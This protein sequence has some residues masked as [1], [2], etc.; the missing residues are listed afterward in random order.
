M[1]YWYLYDP[2]DNGRL[3]YA[4]TAA[5]MADFI[6]RSRHDLYCVFAHSW[7][8]YNIINGTVAHINFDGHRCELVRVKEE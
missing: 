6:G 7:S 5:E 1:N 2:K 8:K 3:V 4:G